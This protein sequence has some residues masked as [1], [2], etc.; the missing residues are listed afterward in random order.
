[1]SLDFETLA[2]RDSLV[3]L[4]AGLYA[5]GLEPDITLVAEAEDLGISVPAIKSKID[6][7][8]ED[9]YVGRELQFN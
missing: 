8:M 1:M 9:D 7:L 6:E 2:R 4:I 5:D 3:E